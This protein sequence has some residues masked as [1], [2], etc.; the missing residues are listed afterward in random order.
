MADDEAN[1]AT[2]LVA[3]LSGGYIDAANRDGQGNTVCSLFHRLFRCS[4]GGSVSPPRLGSPLA[5][6]LLDLVDIPR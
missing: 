4:A 2:L 6:P 3:L 1:D 5:S